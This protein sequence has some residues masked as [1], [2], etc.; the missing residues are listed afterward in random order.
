MAEEIDPGF[1]EKVGD[2]LTALG[3]AKVA[4]TGL[5][6]ELSKEI[7]NDAILFWQLEK[8]IRKTCNAHLWKTANPPEVWRTNKSQQYFK[9]AKSNA[10]KTLSDSYVFPNETEVLDLPK[11]VVVPPT[12]PEVTPE[13]SQAPAK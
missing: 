5:D 13:C 12:Q 7:E 8:R 2:L 6:V 10:D 3:K 11:S 9:M 4:L 1:R